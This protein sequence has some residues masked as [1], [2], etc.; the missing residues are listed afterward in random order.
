M[1]VQIK[2]QSLLIITM[3]IFVLQQVDAQITDGR[4]LVQQ[5]LLKT[6]NSN[7]K[8]SESV[9]ITKDYT[10]K[11]TGVRHIYANQ[12]INGIT[13]ADGAYSLH[14]TNEKSTAADNM[15]DVGQI[16]VKPLNILINA[17]TAAQ[18]LMNDI[19]IPASQQIKLKT[20]STDKDQYTIFSRNESKIWDIPCRLVYYHDKRTKLLIPAWEVQM[21][22]VYKKHYWQAFIDAATGK[23]LEKNDLILHCNFGN[24]FATD[25]DLSVVASTPILENNKAFTPVN[26]A[27]PVASPSAIVN[28]YRV[29]DA[30]F[31]SPI[32]PGAVHSLVGTA[33]S[34]NASVDGWHKVANAT[35]YNYTRGN[36]V[37]AFQDPSPGPLGGVPSA[38]PLR[39]AYSNNGVG[40]TPVA[41]EPF[42]FDYPVNL[43]NQP[44]TYR[45]GAI[46]N[47]FYWNNLMHDVFYEFGFTEQ[48]GNF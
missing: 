38:D 8:I 15:L 7:Q 1:K 36:N 44:E 3:L 18:T 41:S 11:T 25:D 32:D 47:L 22:D 43:A 28:T 34:K 27:K 2:L 10:D 33:G 37:W 20:I 13:V 29:Y 19:N 14:I 46:T 45:L 23:Q 26:S 16:S 4:A 39:T 12:Q 40:G 48:G 31:E 9:N 21:M 5:S 42:G 35:T 24:T 6:N 17:T 30:P